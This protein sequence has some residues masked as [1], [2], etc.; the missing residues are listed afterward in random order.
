MVPSNVEAEEDSERLKVIRPGRQIV[1]EGHSLV[2]RHKDGDGEI[3]LGW[4]REVGSMD[5]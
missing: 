5:L 2:L 4:G 3:V 1:P